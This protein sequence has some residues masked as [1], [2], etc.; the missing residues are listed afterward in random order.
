M[1]TYQHVIDTKAVKLTINKIPDYWVVRDLS[2]R[3][4][5]IDLMIEIFTE[6]GIDKDG[7]TKYISTGR[8]CYLQ[9]KGT[10]SEIKVN[11]DKSVSFNLEKDFLLYA[12]KFPTPFILT[13]VCTLEGKEAIYFVWLQRYIIDILDLKTPDWREKKQDE[14]AIRIP[15]KNILPDNYKKIE[16]IAS[17]IKYIEEYAEFYE[18]YSLM[19]PGY[20][21]MVSGEFTKAQFHYFIT[22]LKR[23]RNLST[24]LEFNNC[25]VNQDDISILIDFI[26]NI[27]DSKY[28]PKSINDF[29]NPLIYNL[30]LLLAD[31]FMRI[32]LENMI[33]ENENDTVF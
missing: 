30:D 23:I 9:I 7:H 29:P 32:F 6:N 15:P 8:V 1:R 21:V 4:Y 22:E 17:R 14:F 28:K 25:Q 13:R 20:E 31:N 33:A 19:T 26:I 12:E 5:G 2:E 27:R 24:L 16:I 18:R 11:K 10:N 3:D